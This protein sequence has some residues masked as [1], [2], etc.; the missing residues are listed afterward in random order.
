MRRPNNSI[1]ILKGFIVGDQIKVWCPYCREFHT[2][3][4]ADGFIAMNHHR[5]AH[6]HDRSI[7]GKT[8]KSPFEEQGY[9][10]EPFTKSE[11]K[12]IGGG[13]LADNF[14]TYMPTNTRPLEKPDL[15]T[16]KD[17]PDE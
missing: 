12:Q 10:I 2:H 11:L 16:A 1:P 4:L 8:V 14:L 17:K 3:G 15:K 7:K 6:C 9:Y 13:K 5:V